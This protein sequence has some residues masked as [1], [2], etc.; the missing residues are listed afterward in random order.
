MRFSSTFDKIL[1]G[2]RCFRVANVGYLLDSCGQHNPLATQLVTLLVGALQPEF[3][4]VGDLK[5]FT[6][7]SKFAGK[8]V[9]F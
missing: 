4:Q 5:N 8:H 3:K 2:F 9:D 7:P 1:G 6:F